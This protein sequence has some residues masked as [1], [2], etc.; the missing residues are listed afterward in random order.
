MRINFIGNHTLKKLYN[1]ILE[2]IITIMANIGY[3]RVSTRDQSLD[4]QIDA[5]SNFGCEKY[6]AKKLVGVK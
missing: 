5:V 6:L 3:A 2:R 4:L 1:A